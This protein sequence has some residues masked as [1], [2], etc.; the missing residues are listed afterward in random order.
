MCS[1]SL[2]VFKTQAWPLCFACIS[3][4]KRGLSSSVMALTDFC[5]FYCLSLFQGL[6]L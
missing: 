6:I 2:T 1:P 3:A 5:Q 4:P